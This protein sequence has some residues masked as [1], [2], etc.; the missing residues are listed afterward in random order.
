MTVPAA[1]RW[2][3]LERAIAA[4]FCAF[5]AVLTLEWVSF[6]GVAG[7]LLKPFHLLAL[8][9]IA[10][11]LAR[12]RASSFLL[13]VWRR[14]PGVFGTYFLFL[15]VVAVAGL[16]HADHY[17]SSSELVRLAF[18]SGTSLV[19]AA[20]FLHVAGRRSQRLLAWTGVVT[21]GV[22]VVGLLAASAAAN[23]NPVGLVA[24]ALA[25]N[26]PDLI[27]HRLFRAAFR[28]KEDL[29]EAG[30]NLRHKVFS[31][32]L[33]ALFL[34]LALYPF[35]ERR[36]RSARVLLVTVTIGGFGLLMLS[37]SRSI[38]L[39]LAVTLL[40]V[41]LRVVVRGRAPPRQ[42]ALLGMAVLMALVLI[43]SPLGGLVLSRFA[44]TQSYENRATAVSSGF[45]TQL[46]GAALFG[47]QKASIDR[48]PHNM[49]LDGWLAGGLVGAAL[50]LVFLVSYAQV[51]TREVRR[52]LTAGPGWELPVSQL[53]VLGIG[54]IP[55]VRAM[56][57]GNGLHMV[58]WTA[59]GV[60]LGL[61]YANRRAERR[62]E[63]GAE[64]TPV[65]S[66]GR[67]AVPV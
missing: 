32:L 19:V 27:G 40:F 9:F 17:V 65:G 34:G 62:L 51:W 7:G 6:G 21:T 8:L 1:A 5:V 58:E 14:Y 15:A 59:V 37:L 29:A 38:L 61:T 50:I 41:P 47:A 67:A 42:A 55:L 56:T 46:E 52:Y 49:V 44:D 26:D 43:L 20:L 63:A 12:W 60:F 25:K 33:V 31:A 23:Q 2:Q 57:A 66:R 39:C 10:L 28:S 35:G 16:A 54:L 24:E 48:T 53:W 11:C 45:V 64:L 13:P 3:P 18:Y 36:R 22:L 4:V 30:A